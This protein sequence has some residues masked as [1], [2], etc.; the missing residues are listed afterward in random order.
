MAKVS[1]VVKH[2]RD[3][4]KRAEEEAGRNFCA[5]PARPAPPSINQWVRV[6]TKEAGAVDGVCVFVDEST[7]TYQVYFPLLENTQTIDTEDILSYGRGLEV[8]RF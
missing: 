4:Q 2:K 8:P 7:E 5:A 1:P 6:H 3:A